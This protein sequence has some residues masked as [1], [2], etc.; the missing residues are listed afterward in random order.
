M[1][2]DAMLRETVRD[3]QKAPDPDTRKTYYEAIRD[4][5][6]PPPDMAQDPLT[7][8]L[9]AA[10]P[11]AP[12]LLDTLRAA[13]VPAAAGVTS[14]ADVLTLPE[15]ERVVW[16]D[17]PPPD[18]AAVCSV[19]EPMVLSA[20]GGT[21]KSYLTLHLAVRGCG[22][23]APARACGLT[24][25]PGGV[26]LVSYEDALG[27]LGAR[28]AAL[29]DRPDVP[30]ADLSH[31]QIVPDP[32]P[33]WAPQENGTGAEPT[34][35]FAALSARALADRP[36]LILIDPLSAAAG[37]VNVN[38]GG[39]ARVCMRWLIQLSIT[40]GA[41]VLIVAHDTKAAR[42]EA[43]AGGDPGA[44]AVAGSGQWFDA[45]RGVVYLHRTADGQR[46]LECL[47]ANHGRAGWARR[48][49]E[50]MSGSTFQ[51]F[52]AHGPVLSGKDVR[53][54]RKATNGATWRNDAKDNLG[55][56]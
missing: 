4:A 52:D 22:P 54:D 56:D 31:L 16:C 8:A 37:G 46:Q 34:P 23:E 9:E 38:E 24:M 7:T 53:T 33:L 3:Y 47:K 55:F 20:P 41:G 48:L 21:G 51:G 19:G 2:N 17:A 27:R 30:A 44:G 36:S 40:S 15:P 10:D 12:D 49:V 11:D 32:L 45:A 35:A 6:R 43:R 18:N 5:L 26:L 42:N 1:M 13:I 28:L 29:Q 25:R 14:A 50:V 39:A